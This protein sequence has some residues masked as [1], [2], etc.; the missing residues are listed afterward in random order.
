[1]LEEIGMVLLGLG[2]SFG[3]S[4]SNPTLL[5]RKPPAVNLKRE[6]LRRD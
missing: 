4:Q 3:R 6:A 5:I 2:S 1:M